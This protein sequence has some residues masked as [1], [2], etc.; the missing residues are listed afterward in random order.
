MI[1]AT[2]LGVEAIRMRSRTIADAQFDTRPG[3]CVRLCLSDLL[4]APSR[5]LGIGDLEAKAA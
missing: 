3:G 5:V 2:R 1:L 4:S